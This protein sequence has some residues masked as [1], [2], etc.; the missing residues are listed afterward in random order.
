MRETDFTCDQ[1]ER[2]TRGLFPGTNYLAR[3]FIRAEKELE[4]DDPLR[5]KIARAYDAALILS[6]HI[7]SLTVQRMR[8]DQGYGVPPGNSE[9]S[10]PSAL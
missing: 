5:I 3:L 6:H 9:A 1:L 8:R 4:P 2:L 7:H 10:P